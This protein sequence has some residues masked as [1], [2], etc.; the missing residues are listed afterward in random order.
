MLSSTMRDIL[1]IWSKTK[2]E[3]DNEGNIQ[4][5]HD[6]YSGDKS[7]D[8]EDD[9]DVLGVN[10]SDNRDSDG[11]ELRECR[12]VCGRTASPPSRTN[13]D[14]NHDDD[15]DDGAS[16]EYQNVSLVAF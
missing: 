5:N 10:E 14:Q 2:M 3:P 8:Q 4:K 15:D 9:D 6:I 7:I 12:T 11:R 13:A 16:A 1:D